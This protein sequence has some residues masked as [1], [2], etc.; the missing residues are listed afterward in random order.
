MQ[1]SRGHARTEERL[2][3]A[4]PATGIVFPGA[5]QVFPIIVTPVAW[6]ANLTN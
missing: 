5:A 3:Q 6:M 4:V 1:C 2:L